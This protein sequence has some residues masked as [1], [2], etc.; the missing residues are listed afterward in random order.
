[1]PHRIG[2]AARDGQRRIRI[3]AERQHVALAAEAEVEAPTMRAALD[4]QEQHQPV[5]ITQPPAWIARLD[6]A[7]RRV[8]RNEVTRHF[9]VTAAFSGSQ[10]SSYCQSYSKAWKNSRAFVQPRETRKKP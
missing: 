5:A 6:G 8:G 3:G 4:E 10:Q 9:G 7:N 1:L 2:L